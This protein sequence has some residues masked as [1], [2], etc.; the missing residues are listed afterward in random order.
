MTTNTDRDSPLP[1]QGLIDTSLFIATESDRPL[2]EELLPDELL[3]S[4][5]TYA[6]LYAGVLA[7]D[8]VDIRAQRLATLQSIAGLE[9]L[10]VDRHIGEIWAQLRISL[11]NKKRRVNVNDLWIASTALAHNLTLYTQDNDFAPIAEISSLDVV[12][13]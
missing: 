7:A 5:I 10:P 12:I 8:K 1:T 6:E 13:V 9:L 2:K 4:A 3:V 11:R